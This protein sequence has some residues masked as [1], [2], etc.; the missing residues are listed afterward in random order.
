MLGYNK[1]PIK[2]AVYFAS[3]SLL[4]VSEPNLLQYYKAKRKIISF[5]HCSHSGVK[6]HQCGQCEKSFMYAEGLIKH[7]QVHTLGS[8]RECSTCKQH[9]QTL[10]ELKEHALV[11]TLSHAVERKRMRTKYARNLFS[12]VLLHSNSLQ[13]P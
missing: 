12:L 10:K 9:F 8:V 3:L 13:L 4:V 5:P 1:D 2:R 11:K 6:R 7:R